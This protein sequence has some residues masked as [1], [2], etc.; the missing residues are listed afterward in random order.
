MNVN[1]RILSELRRSKERGLLQS[2]LVK[3]LRVSKSTISEALAK[4]EKAGVVVREVEAGK[5]LRVWLK[6]FY[7][8]PI[9]GLL[10]LG[11]LKA[12]EYACVLDS[13][14][15]LVR[16]YDNAIDLT[17]DL[18]LGRID[19]AASPFV[20]QVMFGVMMKNLKILRSVAYNGSGIVFGGAENGIFGSTELSAM[21]IMLRIVKDEI[22]LKKFEFFSTP[23][24]MI[25]SLGKLNG[26]A[27]WEPYFSSI[28]GD[29]KFFREFIGDH[30]CCTLAVNVNS[31]EENGDLIE[32]FLE[33]YDK[34]KPNIE[35]VAEKC[36]FA[37]DDVER[38]ISSYKFVKEIREDDL[39]EFLKLARIE[40]SEESLK[41]V[42]E[43]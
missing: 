31:L 32:E 14:E 43:L 6:E 5:S 3:R 40:V 21:E 4:L 30:P 9:K 41:T 39:V 13:F 29:K 2:E 22:G 38:S 7:P 26:I 28:S 11:I 17:K 37:K 15:G 8:K 10:K 20:T 19:L 25:S 18:V 42:L 36:G 12:S 16:V 24:S 34:S 1:E 35:R 33:R 27:I 23:E